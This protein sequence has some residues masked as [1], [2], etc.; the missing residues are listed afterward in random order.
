MAPSPRDTCAVPCQFRGVRKP[1]SAE[2]LAACK[3]ELEAI[4][5]ERNGA[6]N[7]A[8]TINWLVLWNMNNHEGNEWISF[9]YFPQ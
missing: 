4:K 8:F 5:K 2:E 9:N 6:E 7:G 1:L 3:E